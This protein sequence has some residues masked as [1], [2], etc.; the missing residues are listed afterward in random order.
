MPSIGKFGYVT[1][2]HRFKNQPLPEIKFADFS[3]ARKQKKIKGHFTL[4]LLD[5]IKSSIAEN[6]QVI[7]FQNRRGY[8]PYVECNDCNHIPNCPNCAVSLTYH[9]YQNE[10]ICHYCGYKIFFDDEMRKMSIE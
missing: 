9:I 8:A 1:L 10:I 3:K 2:N 6:K 4:A 7:L 5:Q